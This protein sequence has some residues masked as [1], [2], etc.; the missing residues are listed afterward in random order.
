[1]ASRYTIEAIFDDEFR[2]SD[3]ESSDDDGKDI[4][5]YVGEPVLRRTDVRNLG[6]S[7]VAG[8]LVDREEGTDDQLQVSEQDER[9]IS[10][11][12][13]TSDHECSDK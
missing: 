2:L 3:G 6:E 11:D 4:Y 10:S 9:D 12:C 13:L 7:I 8:H 1:M 5:G